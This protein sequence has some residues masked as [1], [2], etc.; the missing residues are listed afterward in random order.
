MVAAARRVEIGMEAREWEGSLLIP[1]M[2]A[3]TFLD[4]RWVTTFDRSAGSSYRRER[5]RLAS[6]LPGFFSC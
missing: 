6:F 5:F 1:T 2:R 3:K 4:R